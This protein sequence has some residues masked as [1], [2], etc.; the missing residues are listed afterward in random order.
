MYTIYVLCILFQVVIFMGEI[1]KHQFLIVHLIIFLFIYIRPG[2]HLLYFGTSF[3][4][5]LGNIVIEGLLN[6]LSMVYLYGTLVSFQIKIIASNTI[7][8]ISLESGVIK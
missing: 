3:K 1:I 2:Y 7:K 4:M 8:L 5:V 6:T